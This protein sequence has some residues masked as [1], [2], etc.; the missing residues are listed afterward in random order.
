MMHKWLIFECLLACFLFSATQTRAQNRCVVID[1]ETEMPVSHASLFTKE[2]GRFHS[3]ITNERGR[4][5]VGWTFRKLTVSHLNYER[6][7]LSRLTDTIRLVPKYH[8]A[9]E[10]V[11]SSE[12][13]WIRPLLK[14][15]VRQKNRLYGWNQQAL[16]YHY[17]TQNIEG[18]KYYHFESDGLLR[19]NPQ[20]DSQFQLA[21]QQA[22][23]TSVDSTRLTD[24]TNLRRMLYEDFVEEMDNGF[25]RSHRFSVSDRD[26][27]LDDDEVELI[28]RAKND[29]SDHG[30][31]VID[32]VRCVIRQVIRTTGLKANKQMRASAA[33]LAMSRLMTG[34]Q[35]TAWDVDYGVNYFENAGNWYPRDIRYKFFFKARENITEKDEASFDSLTG[36]GFSNMESTITLKPATS[37]PDTCEFKPL[38]RTWYI[39]INTDSERE[40]EIELANMPAQF[41]LYKEE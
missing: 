12:P 8:L 4:A 41:V 22:C 35:I 32:T 28:F 10:I 2:G 31:F 37:V 33:L 19:K 1:D 14:R 17:L 18:N 9:A 29:R 20:D 5:T 21:Q 38:P 15:F 16:S 7:T 6:Q 39:K 3:A 13:A 34:Y 24:L 26:D 23:I 25:I 30:R 36:G 40:Y 11:V 27:D